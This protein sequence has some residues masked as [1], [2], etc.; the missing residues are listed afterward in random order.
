MHSKQSILI[1]TWLKISDTQ[2]DATYEEIAAQFGDL[3][4]EVASQQSTPDRERRPMIKGKYEIDNKN[5]HFATIL[6]ASKFN[7]LT[8][9]RYSENFK[10]ELIWSHSR[11]QEYQRKQTATRRIKR[12]EKNKK[13]TPKFDTERTDR[14][15]IENRK[16][17]DLGKIQQISPPLIC[18]ILKRLQVYQ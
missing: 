1:K 7:F 14:S 15:F 16:S 13:A 11:K 2:C 10:S 18:R 17:D 12:T 9:P 4:Q 8:I 5:G 6:Y 3:S